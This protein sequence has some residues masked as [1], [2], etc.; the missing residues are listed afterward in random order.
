MNKT[1][2]A[3]NGVHIP[4][5]GFGVYKIPKREVFEQVIGVANFEIR[6]LEQLMKHASNPPMVNQLETHPEFPQ[7]ELHF[8]V[9]FT[10][11]D[12]RNP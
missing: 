2:K 1:I 10:E 3:I 6:H 7:Y 4:Q 9:A 5:L 12:C 11:G 8:E